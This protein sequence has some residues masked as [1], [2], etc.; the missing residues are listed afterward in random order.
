MQLRNGIVLAAPK[1]GSGKTLVTCAVIEA[2]KEKNV[3]VVSYK[4]GPDY[5]DPMF[6]R[7]VLGVPGGNLDTFF[8]GEEK[9][10]ELFLSQTKKESFAVVEGVMGLFDGLGGVKEEA[11]TYH[12]AK[13]L[14]LPIVLVVDAHGM[15]R[16]I[17]PILAGFL[18]YDTEHL[19]KG[20]I[21]NRVSRMFSSSLANL[22]AS[23]LDIKVLG[24]FP[25]Q[26]EL[27]LE[28]RHLGLKMP[29][30]K[31]N[32]KEQVQIAARCLA[33]TVD[34][35]ALLALGGASVEAARMENDNVE[36]ARMGNG[37]VEAARMEN[38]NVEAARMEKGNVEAAE[39]RRLQELERDVPKQ[40]ME[41]AQIPYEAAQEI[42]KKK[43]IL[44]VAYDEAF[45]FYYQE[46]FH[47]LEQAG[48]SL[49]FFSPLHD[50]KLPNG[51]SALLLG[52]GYPEL[53]AKELAENIEMKQAVQA[54][55]HAGM[56]SVAEC[57]GFMYLH[58][59][60]TDEKGE[61]Y[62]M[63][64]I[65]PADCSYQGKLVHFGYATFEEQEPL[66]LKKGETIKGHEFHYFD[67]TDNGTCCK[68]V[69]PTGKRQ[70]N[71]VHAGD[72]HW[73]GFPHLYYPSNPEFVAHF[74]KKALEYEKSGL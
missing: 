21:L 16:S 17:L 26:K 14:S 66:F 20:V 42:V 51:A 28:S 41:S 19:I 52:G 18:S 48:F 36:A 1:S 13:T 45:C 12:L 39:S 40:Q 57:G 15:G 3:P 31:K 32:L 43:T 2:L 34:L 29:Q 22:I 63:C 53:F 62:P 54:A 72:N 5:I 46:N 70:W 68:A 73:W 64:H 50:K 33:E 58:R 30:E 60:L 37:N 25:E 71:C 47:A 6:H 44:A 9:T 10:R 59:T 11:S 35:D 4:C 27:H 8:T 24:Y 65:L 49:E 7:T 74:Y 56:P 38:G 61:T 55:I 23:E 69:K 67:S